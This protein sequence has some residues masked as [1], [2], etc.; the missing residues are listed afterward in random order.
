[1]IL[2]K[3]IAAALAVLKETAKSTDEKFEAAL[4]LVTEW[5]DEGLSYMSAAEQRAALNAFKLVKASTRPQKVP[6]AVYRGL[7]IPIKKLNTA[8]SSGIPVKAQQ[9]SSWTTDPKVA[10]KYARTSVI[11]WDFVGLIVAIRTPPNFLLYLDN[12]FITNVLKNKSSFLRQSEVVLEGPGITH[13]NRSNILAIVD[14]HGKP[15]K[16]DEYLRGD[17]QLEEGVPA[18][19]AAA[20]KPAAAP[21]KRRAY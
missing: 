20:K 2:D 13:I 4:E 10:L 19:N 15:R 5:V 3:Q 1:M 14:V 9:L 16:V 18:P 17:V 21:R 11:G 8:L 6:A 7:S 12:N